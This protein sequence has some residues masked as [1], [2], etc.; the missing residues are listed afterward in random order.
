MHSR[1]RAQLLRWLT[2]RVLEHVVSEEGWLTGTGI[3]EFGLVARCVSQEC[4]MLLVSVSP[5]RNVVEPLRIPFAC[6]AGFQFWLFHGKFPKPRATVSIETIFYFFF[7]FL[8]F[9]TE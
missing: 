6:Q 5:E 3:F 4:E 2:V 1:P 7:H 8:D 9:Y